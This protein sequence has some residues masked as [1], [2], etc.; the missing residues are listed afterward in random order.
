[1]KRLSNSTGK[2]INLFDDYEDPSVAMFNALF[3]ECPLEG[4]N[5]DDIVRIGQMLSGNRRELFVGTTVVEHKMYSDILY[6]KDR[7]EFNNQD[8]EIESI[9]GHPV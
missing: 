5:P 7:D 8:N 6:G 4:H 1:M 3:Y 9:T 2:R